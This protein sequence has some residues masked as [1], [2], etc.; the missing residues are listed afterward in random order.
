[1]KHT[2]LGNGSAQGALE[3]GQDVGNRR[4]GPRGN[5]DNRGGNGGSRRE[6]A[7]REGGEDGDSG[8]GVHF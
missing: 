1:M 5:S 2:E 8:E 4:V 3:G 6:R 7:E